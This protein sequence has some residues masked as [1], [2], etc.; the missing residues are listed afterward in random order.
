[1]GTRSVGTPVDLELE[2]AELDP[3]LD[4]RPPVAS[5]HF[6]RDDLAGVGF[7][8]PTMDRFGSGSR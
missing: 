5:L 2:H 8:G 4:D 1:M 3:D 7:V 6:T